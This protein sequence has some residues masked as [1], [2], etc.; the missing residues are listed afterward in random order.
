MN[1]RYFW[2]VNQ[3]QQKII[4]VEWYPGLENLTDYFTK[5]FQKYIHTIRRHIYLHT[6]YSPRYLPRALPPATLRV[7]A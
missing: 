5:Y 3:V 7:C 1:M 4:K 2:A 6:K